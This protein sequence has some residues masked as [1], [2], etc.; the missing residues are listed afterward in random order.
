M[1]LTSRQLDQW[2]R[3]E[4]PEI[5]PHIYKQ[6]S[7][8]KEAKTLQWKNES[9]FNKWC[10]FN[11]MSACRRIQI[12]SY[13]LSCTKLKS[14]W[15]KNL[16]IQMNTLNLIEENVGNCLEPMATGC[17]FLTRIRIAQA[18]RSTINK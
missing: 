17:K 5:N 9:I 3:I 13:L 18:L 8:D 6:L 10:W 4:D 16:N 15:I 7:F 14:R 1:V 11:W 12:C 2:N